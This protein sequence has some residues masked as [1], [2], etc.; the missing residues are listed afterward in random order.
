[1]LVEN[2]PVH[3]GYMAQKVKT[4]FKVPL[5]PTFIRQWR[6]HRGLTIEALAD[7]VATKLGRFTHASLSRIERGK[8]PY[9]QPILEALA[10]ALRTDTWSLLHRDP[11]DPDGI[12][13]IWDQAKPAQRKMI[14]DIA[15][16]L[17][18]IAS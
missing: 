16:T 14:V 7:R 13:S 15:K 1:M 4:R 12:W 10:D 2:R 3:N 9:S 17:L 8:Q 5:Q 11:T 6:A 18:K